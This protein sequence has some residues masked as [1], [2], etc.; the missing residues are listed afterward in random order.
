MLGID[1]HCNAIGLERDLRKHDPNVET[2][3]KEYD[4][5]D[6]RS[7]AMQMIT[8]RVDVCLADPGRLH[9]PDA[10]GAR[11]PNERV[12][13]SNELLGSGFIQHDARVDGARDS[14]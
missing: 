8:Q 9:A 12:T 14:V 5:D 3:A 13:A 7:A 2:A 6:V 11:K 4:V 10:V 1:D